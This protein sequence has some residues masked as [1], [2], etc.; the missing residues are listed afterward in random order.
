M[1]KRNVSECSNTCQLASFWIRYLLLGNKQWRYNDNWKKWNGN[2]LACFSYFMLPAILCIYWFDLWK[3]NRDKQTKA[4]T[5]NIAVT[6]WCKICTG[7]NWL[8]WFYWVE[9]FELNFQV[10][11]SFFFSFLFLEDIH[12]VTERDPFALLASASRHQFPHLKFRV[13]IIRVVG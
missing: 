13:R 9:G 3:K 5:H 2:I 7:A 12:S 11:S 8:E 4:T 6:R 10:S 1:V